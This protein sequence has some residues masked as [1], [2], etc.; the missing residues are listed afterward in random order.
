MAGSLHALAELGRFGRHEDVR[1]HV[2]M[3]TLTHFGC[4]QTRASRRMWCLAARGL[5]K[6]RAHPGPPTPCRV[7]SECMDTAEVGLPG[8]MAVPADGLAPG[9]RKATHRPVPRLPRGNL[10]KSIHRKRWCDASIAGLRRCAGRLNQKSKRPGSF[11]NPGLCVQSWE[12]CAMR[13]LLPDA[14]GPPP[15][16]ARSRPAAR[17]RARSHPCPARVGVSG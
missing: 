4:A 13:F 14:P 17:Q 12:G 5:A 3:S 7:A 10:S 16:P 8:R 1:R 9:K 2:F 11:R 15:G 6:D